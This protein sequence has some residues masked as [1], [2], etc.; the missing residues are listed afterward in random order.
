MNHDKFQMDPMRTAS[1]R[2]PGTC[3]DRSMNVL[4]TAAIDEIAEW[5]RTRSRPTRRSRAR[6]SPRGKDAASAPAPISTRWTACR[7]AGN[8]RQRSAHRRGV[9]WKAALTPRCARWRPAASRSRPPS[10]ALALGGGLEVAL[11]CHYRVVADNPKTSSACRKRKVGLLPR[12]RRH[13]APA[14]PD[15][16]AGRAAADAR[17][18]GSIR[19]RPGA[20]ASFTR[21]CPR[22][23]LVAEAKRWIKDER[24]MPC[25]PGTRRTIAFPAAGPTSPAAPDFIVGNAMLPQTDLRQLSGAAQHHEVRL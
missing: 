16:R 1:S 7:A 24:A 4:S 19:K 22:V 18:Q 23:E 10:T 14:A 8:S 17:R 13:A 25:S 12:R 5:R 20:R 6:S 15:R 3:P 11:A 9:R 21:S 2:S